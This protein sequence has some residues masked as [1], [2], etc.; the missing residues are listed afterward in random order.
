MAY[1]WK[2]YGYSH[3]PFIRPWLWC[4]LVSLIIILSTRKMCFK[5]M[6]PAYDS[7]LWPSVLSAVAL[8]DLIF[9][10]MSRNEAPFSTW[11]VQQVCTR[12]GLCVSVQ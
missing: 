2:I 5:N 6:A 11:L 12:T 10:V 1:E 9:F 4:H 7:D 8:V 3:H